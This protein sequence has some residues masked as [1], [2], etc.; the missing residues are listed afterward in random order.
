[1][2]GGFSNL[3]TQDFNIYRTLFEAVTVPQASD[4]EE[5]RSCLTRTM[6]WRTILVRLEA[7]YRNCL[8]TL[9]YLNDK[10]FCGLLMDLCTLENVKAVAAYTK[11]ARSK[12]GGGP[13]EAASGA[14]RGAMYK[15]VHRC[16]I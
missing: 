16:H 6:K 8:K 4:G 7:V 14:G 3:F 15:I 2:A 5:R 11:Y 1:M 10:N 13:E 9:P 12:G